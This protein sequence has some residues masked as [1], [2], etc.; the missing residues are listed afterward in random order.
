MDDS[1]DLDKNISQIGVSY[2]LYLDALSFAL[3]RGEVSSPMLQRQF[4]LPF[5][6]SIKIMDLLELNGIIEEK[7]SPNSTYKIKNI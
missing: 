7:M 3:D 1:N 4:H 6:I 2:D 5:T